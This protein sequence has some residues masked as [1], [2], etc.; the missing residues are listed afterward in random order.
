MAKIKK[1]VKKAKPRVKKEKKS[2][3][4]P[5]LKLRAKPAAHAP[6]PNLASEQIKE[7]KKKQKYFEGLGRRKTSIAQVRLFS[8]GEK[9][10][11][12]SELSKEQA[13][14][15]NEKSLEQYFPT[16]ELREIALSPFKLMDCI[17]QF[18]VSVKV[19]GGG[20]HSQSEAIRHGIAKSLVIFNPDFKKRLK[21]AGFLTRDPRMRERKK[22]GLKRARRAPQWQKR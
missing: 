5:A 10:P 7:A 2:K 8:S 12:E 19:K 17:S 13:F 15:I 16:F 4:E 14:L 22:F 20:L 6:A 11:R 18:N 1:E 9:T 3:K 21:K